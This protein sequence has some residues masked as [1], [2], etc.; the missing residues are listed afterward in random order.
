MLLPVIRQP[1]RTVP[2][3]CALI[4]H[5]HIYTLHHPCRIFSCSSWRKPIRPRCSNFGPWIYFAITR[6]APWLSL[7][8]LALTLDSRMTSGYQM[9]Y[10]LPNSGSHSLKMQGIWHSRTRLTSPHP[11]SPQHALH[12]DTRDP[13]S[14]PHK[15]HGVHTAS[16][17]Q[18][19]RGAYSHP[20]K[21][22][23]VHTAR[24][25]GVEFI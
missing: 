11:I 1:M 25:V 7:K 12:S 2:H 22:H 3:A 16:T 18:G 20:H 21:T 17:P 8:L 13:Y 4:L 23:G 9:R 10:Q 15:T 6:F 19:T 5:V 24:P 14:H